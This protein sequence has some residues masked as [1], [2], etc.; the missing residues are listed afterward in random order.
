MPALLYGA[1]PESAKIVPAK[2]LRGEQPTLDKNEPYR[3][4]LAKWMTAPDNPYFARAMANRFWYQLFGRGLVTPVDD[5]HADNG[6][7]HPDLL[8]T[9]TEQLKLSDFDVKFLIRAICNS[10]AYQRSSAGS[11]RIG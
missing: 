2:F 10:E 3:P 7:S 8:A 9:L 1:L 11:V 6:P 4:T 5:M